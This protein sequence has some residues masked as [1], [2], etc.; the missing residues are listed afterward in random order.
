LLPICNS[1]SQTVVLLPSGAAAGWKLEYAF[2]AG[3]NLLCKCGPSYG[4]RLRSLQHG[5]RRGWLEYCY[6]V[7]EKM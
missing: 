5:C 6:L 3:F 1:G 7:I 2:W 4:L